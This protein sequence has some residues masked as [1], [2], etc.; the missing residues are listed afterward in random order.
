MPHWTHGSHLFNKD[1][2]DDIQK[3]NEWNQKNTKF[4]NN[5]IKTW[6]IRDVNRYNIAVKNNLNYLVI[7]SNKIN[8]VIEQ[9]ENYINKCEYNI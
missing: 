6:P 4:Y 9:F 7:Y 3:P 2:K 1:N 5:T 8:E